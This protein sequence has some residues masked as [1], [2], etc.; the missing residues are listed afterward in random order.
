MN[1]FCYSMKAFCYKMKVFWYNR[2]VVDAGKYASGIVM[3][4]IAPPRK[5]LRGMR[6]VTRRPRAQKCK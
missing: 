4:L 3:K 5:E 2:S 6:F 1:V